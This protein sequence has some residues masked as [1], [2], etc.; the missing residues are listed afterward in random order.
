M[1][2][3]DPAIEPGTLLVVDD[4]EVFRTRLVRAMN[5]RG[6]T[7]AGAADYDEAMAVAYA[8]ALNRLFGLADGAVE[9]AA[10]GRKREEK[11]S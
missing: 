2:A 1:S 8:D 9:P 7:A 3:V 11:V 4:D 6:F 10:A 5:A